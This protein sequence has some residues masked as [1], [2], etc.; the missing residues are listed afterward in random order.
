MTYKTP[1]IYLHMEKP[2]LN[3]P[4]LLTRTPAFKQNTLSADIVDFTFF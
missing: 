4:V 2:Y 1:A 3:V